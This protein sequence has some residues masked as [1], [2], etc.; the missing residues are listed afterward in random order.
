MGLF[1]GT[2][3]VVYAFTFTLFVNN[4]FALGIGTVIG[5]MFLFVAHVYGFAVFFHLTFPHIPSKKI[6]TV[7]LV[8]VALVTISHIKFFPYPEIDKKGFIHF[9]LSPFTWTIFVLF[10]T[11]GLLPLSFAFAREAINKKY[12]RARSGFVA[13][14][15]LFLVIANGLQSL[16]GHQLYILA[17][18]VLPGIAYIMLFIAVILR[19]EASAV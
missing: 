14:S 11:L 17:F 16:V 8:L 19:V 6:I 15:V 18:L 3:A 7:G 13:F 5:G 2:S 1:T 4:P 12:L 9:N 10:S